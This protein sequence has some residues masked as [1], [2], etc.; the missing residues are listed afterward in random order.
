MADLP[1]DGMEEVFP[2]W[3]CGTDVFGHSMSKKAEE[4]SNVTV[5]CL[6]V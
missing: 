5:F 6:P 4:N 2:F 1:T 3:Y